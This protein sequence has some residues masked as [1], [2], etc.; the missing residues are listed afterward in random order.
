MRS[1]VIGLAVAVVI[2]GAFGAIFASLIIDIIM[3]PLA[4]ITGGV[5][6]SDTNIKACSQYFQET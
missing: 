5:D 4:N 2:G 1:N 3:S 6:L